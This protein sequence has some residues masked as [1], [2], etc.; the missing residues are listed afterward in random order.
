MSET[1]NVLYMSVQLG[2]NLVTGTALMPL[3][4]AG[5]ANSGFGGFTLIAAQFCAGAATGV[6][7]AYKLNLVHGGYRGTVLGG[8][9]SDQLG[10][11]AA[12][13]NFAADSVYA[14]TLTA[15][16]QRFAEG[17]SLSIQKIAEGTNQSPE[18]VLHLQYVQGR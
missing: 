10:G 8:T 18:G 5:T 4:V 11:T 14:F 2:G 16:Q 9:V 7:T 17:D 6:G 15:A 12:A 3:I 1:Q 13:S